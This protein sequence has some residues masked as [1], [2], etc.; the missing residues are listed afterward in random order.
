[1]L[2]VVVLISNVYPLQLKFESSEKIHDSVHHRWLLELSTLLF[3][4][5]LFRL[6]D[7]F[8]Q[9]FIL[10]CPFFLSSLPLLFLPRFLFFFRPL[11]HFEKVVQGIVFVISIQIMVK[12]L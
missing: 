12:V 2:K 5:L 4:L 9:L 1:M 10:L 11:M 8:L 7:L 3:L 6:L